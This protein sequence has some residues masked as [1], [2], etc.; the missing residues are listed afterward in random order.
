MDQREFNWAAYYRQAGEREKKQAESL[1]VK[2]YAEEK[3]RDEL[4]EKYDKITGGIAWKSLD[5]MRKIRSAGGK[6]FGS[7][8]QKASGA[9]PEK[10]GASVWADPEICR[11]ILAAYEEELA[12]QMDPYPDWYDREAKTLQENAACTVSAD[13]AQR[14]CRIISY[15][16]IDAV[17]EQLR[18]EKDKGNWPELLLFAEEPD[19]LSADAPKFALTA[20]REHPNAVF[21][22]ADEDHGTDPAGAG[23]HV[24]PFFKPDWSPD[25]LSGFF[26]FGSYVGVRSRALSSTICETVCKKEITPRERIYRLC[27]SL[28]YQ[29]LF[30]G[31]SKTGADFACHT[32]LIL[33]TGKEVPPHRPKTEG[34]FENTNSD[35]YRSCGNY[36]GYETQYIPMKKELLTKFS[37]YGCAGGSTAL[38]GVGNVYPLKKP[39]DMPT[40]S[41]VIPSK[42]HAGVLKTC[43]SSFLERTDYPENKVEFIV[44]DNGSAEECRKLTESF[45]EEIKTHPMV[46]RTAYL[47]H[48]APFN[49][50][51]MCNAGAKAA[52][53]ELLLLLNDDIEILVNDWLNIL[54]GQSLIPGTG[55]VG[56]KLWYPGFER[57]QHAGITNLAVGPSHK[58]ITFPEDRLYY[59]GHG[60]VSMDMMA[61]TA[62]CL[63]VKR[64]IYDE[65]GGLNEELA[66][67]YN[68]VEFCFHLLKKGY[69]NVQR[70][71]AVL[72]HHESL[73]RGRDDASDE[74]WDR[75]YAERRK[76]YDLYPEYEG[77][78]PY[79]SPYLVQDLAEYV[80]G[81]TD[82][83]VD[84][85]DTTECVR[86]I[87]PDEL[88]SIGS[89]QMQLTVDRV[90]IQRK[91]RMDEPDILLAEGWCYLPGEDN[92]MYEAFLTLRA[93]DG[94]AYVYPVK[95]KYRYDVCSILSHEKNV[96]LAGFACRVQK[97]ELQKGIYQAGLLYRHRGTGRELWKESAETVEVQ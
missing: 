86:I 44:V 91:F 7:G 73:S 77:V 48:R 12:G 25:T 60:A 57:I 33:Y 96:G 64:E 28:T 75:L 90:L 15:Q 65:V 37:S 3:H 47:Y 72:C 30:L 5:V 43:I 54:V 52:E 62:A 84:R 22:Y 35:D 42:D 50:S 51:A 41:V 61:V 56:A 88:K 71:D 74:K 31:E 23:K 20:M 45:L 67:A 95:A 17:L 55:A 39:E 59:Y 16:E 49:F 21:W 38:R 19:S 81:K 14:L 68:D 24:W 32:P 26:Y 6:L 94:A 80:T 36:W 13:E 78:D 89:D 2:L 58:L 53:G 10:E 70:N 8:K 9:D 34:V 83:F 1:M 92:A 18:G 40:V 79:Y 4:Q 85:L 69:R 66:V 93:S 97:K 87:Q 11:E 46:R 63:L 76:L 29:D 82:P 27:L